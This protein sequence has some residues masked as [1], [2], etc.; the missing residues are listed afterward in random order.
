MRD[1]ATRLL[2][3]QPPFEP[4]S[5]FGHLAATAVPGCEEV[6]DGAYR[7]TLR[8]PRGA[9]IVA[10]RPG[11]GAVECRLLL[12]D[13]DDEAV[14]LER[15]R[16]LLDLDADAA[17]ASAAL[18]EDSALAPGVAAAPGRR[19]PRTVD[20]AELAIR[21]VLGQ[22]VSTAAARTHAGR[23]VAALGSSLADPEGGLTHLFPTAEQL[24]DS[25]L[26]ALTGPQARRDALRS[27]AA[28]LASGVVRLEPGAD[29]NDARVGLGALPGIG[30]WTVELVAM[31]ALGDADAFPV[32]DLGVRKG[33]AELGLPTGGALVGHAERWRPWRAYA[34]QYLWATQDHPINRW[35][36]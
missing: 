17:T 13:A 16:Q 25:D 27:L 11:V 18:A 32:S 28:A 26:S 12:D 9:G 22:Q 21:A 23:L 31:R 33:A 5:L 4:S 34:V 10:L 2:A 15:C 3:Y 35:P 29:P 36:P 14:A 1:G 19:I 24:A 8:L 6:R 30:P 20:P 7:R